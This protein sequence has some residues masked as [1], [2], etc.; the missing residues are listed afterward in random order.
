MQR[1]V[2]DCHVVFG[3]KEN[4]HPLKR[5][6]HLRDRNGTVHEPPGHVENRSGVDD[7]FFPFLTKMYLDFGVEI[8]VIPG[9]AAKDEKDFVAIVGVGR[10]GKCNRLVDGKQLD[11]NRKVGKPGTVTT[12]FS[13]MCSDGALPFSKGSL[14]IYLPYL[15]S[16]I[17]NP[18]SLYLR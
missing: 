18:P 3:S 17:L 16:A 6:I 4:V 11:F 12:F 2:P 10:M 9:V 15:V 14:I 13:D 1:D 7:M 5:F 8:I